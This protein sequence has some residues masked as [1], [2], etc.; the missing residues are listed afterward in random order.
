VT[1]VMEPPTCH[2]LPCWCS[3]RL[4]EVMSCGNEE[5]QVYRQYCRMRTYWLV[6]CCYAGAVGSWVVPQA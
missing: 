4:R 2:I 3:W 1:L 5:Q 6:T